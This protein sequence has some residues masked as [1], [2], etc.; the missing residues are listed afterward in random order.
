[1][2]SFQ[3][4]DATIYYEE[5]GQGFPILTF[6]PG[7]MMSTIDFWH[8][9]ASPVD[10]TKVLASDFRV[11]AMDQRNAGG[12]SRAPIRPT[13]GWQTFESDHIALLDHLGIEQC[14]LYGQCI[15]GP[16]I[17]SLLRAQPQRFPC[18]V[19]AQPIGRVGPLPPGRSPN[20]NSWAE[21]LTDHP[22][23][24]E[25]VLDSYYGNL[26]SPGFAYS[27][28]RDFVASCRTPCLVLAGN[29]EAHPY[30]IAEEIARLLPSAEFIPEWKEGEPLAAATTRMKQF[31]SDHTPVRA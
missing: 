1:M 26:Y 22:E 10:P 2:P 7:G 28:D 12:H 20:F 9:P 5:Y 11:I 15:G 18:A 23:A 4:G 24:T 17:L 29:D 27:V 3:N 14:H 8:R 31:L 19:I 25:Q 16:F 30:A 21:K 13:D 6:A